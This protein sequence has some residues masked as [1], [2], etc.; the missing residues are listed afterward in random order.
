MRQVTGAKPLQVQGG[1]ILVE[2]HIGRIGFNIVQ[3]DSAA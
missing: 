3:T 1:S 2:R